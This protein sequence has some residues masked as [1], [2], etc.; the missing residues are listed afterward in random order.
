M[1]YP[2]TWDFEKHG[3]VLEGTYVGAFHGIGRYKNTLYAIKQPRNGKTFTIWGSREIKQALQLRPF[4]KKVRIEFLGKIKDKQHSTGIL[5]YKIN[6]GRGQ[7]PA[8]TDNDRGPRKIRKT[9]AA[10]R[11]SG[12]QYSTRPLSTVGRHTADAPAAKRSHHKKI[13]EIA[14]PFAIAAAAAVQVPVPIPVPLPPP[15]YASQEAFLA[16]W[17][18]RLKKL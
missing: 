16:G 3:K 7:E 1:T 9:A 18:E 12:R 5:H 4:G 10:G 6:V 14:P 2:P 8:T 11:V 13:K 17:K 15:G